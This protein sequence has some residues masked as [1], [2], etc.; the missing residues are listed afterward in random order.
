MSAYFDE[1]KFLKLGMSLDMVQALREA[2]EGDFR[3]RLFIRLKEYDDLADINA[4]IDDPD[5]EML[6]KVDGQGLATWNG[7]AWVKASDDTTGIT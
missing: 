6:I 1:S 2:F 4:N 5:T 3:E 7:A